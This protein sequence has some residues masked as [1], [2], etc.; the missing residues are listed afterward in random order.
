MPFLFLFCMSALH[1][2]FPLPLCDCS[3]FHNTL[4][5]ISPG[6]CRLLS[7]CVVFQYVRFTY[8]LI[9]SFLFITYQ[10]LSFFQWLNASASYFTSVITLLVV[11]LS[12]FPITISINS[13]LLPF[14]PNV[15]LF[16]SFCCRNQFCFFAMCV[17]ID[18]WM[19]ESVFIFNI[20]HEFV[21]NF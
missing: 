13:C 8:C 20:I 15:P 11:F 17:C 9:F 12:S 14:C 7:L 21:K 2:S 19:D 1:T 16:R 5:L 4:S 3:V 18:E 6:V 10:F